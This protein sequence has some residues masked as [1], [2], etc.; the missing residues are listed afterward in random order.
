MQRGG[1]LKYP[2]RLRRFVDWLVATRREYD[3]V[4]GEG[5]METLRHY[6]WV[7]ALMVPLHAGLA[8]LLQQYVAPP[9]HPEMTEW[10][11]TV[12]WAH[13]FMF[14]FAI[15]SGLLSH[16]YVRRGR[17]ATVGAIVLQIAIAVGYFYFGAVISIADLVANAGAGP[18]SFMM[19]CIMFGVLGLMR[20]GISVPLYAGTCMVFAA[21]LSHA[22]IDPIHGISVGIIAYVG[23][24]L[25][26]LASVIVWNQFVRAVVLRRQLSRSNVALVAQQR[27]LAFLADHDTLTGLYNRR[28]FMR[29]A[30]MELAR[31][32]RASCDTQMIM[33]DLDFFKKINDG[34][35]HPVGDAVLKQVAGLLMRGIRTT[36]TVARLGGEE[37]IVLLPDTTREGALAVAEKLRQLVRTAPLEIEDLRVPVTASFGVSG[38]L[39]NQQG[40]VDSIYAAADRALYVAKQLGRDRVEYAEPES[41][42]LGGRRQGLRA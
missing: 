42:E 14:G 38:L 36:D 39:R 21:M 6:R 27:E 33:V 2:P 24:A 23:P 37:F 17:R 3:L 10:A 16:A 5:T 22:P 26:L 1:M 31:A 25:A 15:A 20:P 7:A 32:T 40:T 8:C 9:D 12:K 11:N 30:Q 19:I 29:L 4:Q 34:Y 13:V 18:S 28:E 35:G 41:S